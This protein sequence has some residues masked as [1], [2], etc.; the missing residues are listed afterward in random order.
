MKRLAFLAVVAGLGGAALPGTGRAG[1]IP[2]PATLDRFVNANGSSNGNFTTVQQPNELDTFSAFS[3]ST[4]PVGSPPSAANITVS[5]FLPPLSSESGLQFRGAFNTLPGITVDYA[6]GYTETAPPGSLI[7]DAVLSAS[8]GNNGGTGTVS[9]VEF[10][11]FPDGSGQSLEVSL[12]GS[13]SASLTF[14][15]V[16]AILVQ[17]DIL[18]LGGSAGANVEIV[19]QGFSSSTAV[20]EPAS[21]TLLGLGAAGLA[22]YGWRRQKRAV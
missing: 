9:I 17:T 18:L 1:L 2:L 4:V 21:L 12:P 20:P 8:M 16:P 15:G 11:T 13:S 7:T 22:G 6:L 5:A 10:V 3:Y 14:A 19:N